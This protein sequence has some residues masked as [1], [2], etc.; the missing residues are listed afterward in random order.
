MPV[1]FV[2]A[3]QLGG[4]KRVGGHFISIIRVWYWADSGVGSDGRFAA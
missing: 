3:S 1:G 2:N 4:E